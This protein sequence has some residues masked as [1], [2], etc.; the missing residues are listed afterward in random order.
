M[1]FFRNM[2][3]PRVIILLSVIGGGVLAYLYTQQTARVDELK[4]E[5]S[6]APE[7][8]HEIQVRAMQLRELQ[9]KLEKENLDLLENPDLYIRKVAQQKNVDIGNVEIDPK[10]DEISTGIV[11]KK[12]SIEPQEKRRGK[13]LTRIANFLYQLEEGS[14]QLRITHLKLSQPKS[15]RPHEIVGDLW[16]FE[17]EATLRRRKA[18]E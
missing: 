8:A 4:Q 5:V 17:A 2:T 13:D 16:T 7:V 1:A 11:D 10:E 9:R 14:R 15:V 12:Y 3:F 18:G 6:E